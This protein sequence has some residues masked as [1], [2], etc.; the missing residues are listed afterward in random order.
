[1]R[2]ENESYK[3]SREMVRDKI[4]SL[5]LQWYN[6]YIAGNEDMQTALQTEI[7][8]IIVENESI[9]IDGRW[10]R[11]S[12][13]LFTDAVSDFYMNNLKQFNPHY[14]GKNQSFFAF[15]K[16][17]IGYRIQDCYDKNMGVKR[18]KIE[19]DGKGIT[20]KIKNISLDEVQENFERNGVGGTDWARIQNENIMRD[21]EE[22][23][24]QDAKLMELTI[25]FT[26]ITEHLAGR[27]NNEN[28]QE[29]FK[30]FATENI[31]GALKFSED[32][33]FMKKRERDILSALEN[34]FLD[35]YMTEVCR[36]MKKIHSCPMKKHCEVEA[37][38][39]DKSE[40]RIPF[41]NK[42]YTAYFQ[43]VQNRKVGDSAISMQ[44]SSFK[45]LLWE[46]YKVRL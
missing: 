6:Y 35:Y 34:K 29:Y 30:L 26:Q 46:L 10:K 20:E 40:I 1:M 32:P 22:L 28:K 21:P 2:A 31:T 13:E 17:R 11:I 41:S 39:Q 12:D 19:E 4:N 16:S 23:L 9:I 18:R 44:R 7:F 14:N 42:L 25:L 45:E 8:T 43:R 24:V 27:Q 33:S 38:S 3:N 37:G 36:S 5:G 15:A